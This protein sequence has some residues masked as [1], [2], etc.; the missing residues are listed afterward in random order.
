MGALSKCCPRIR[1]P[2]DLPA[3]VFAFGIAKFV[4]QRM[5]CGAR[6]VGTKRSRAAG[7]RRGQEG[8]RAVVAG[9]FVWRL[10]VLGLVN[11]RSLLTALQ[12]EG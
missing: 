10:S 8:D 7:M 4:E 2:L 5:D 3:C 12:Q 1:P 6:M 11:S 9:A